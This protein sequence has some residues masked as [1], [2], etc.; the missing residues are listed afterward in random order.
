MADAGFSPAPHT[1][2]PMLDKHSGAI[3]DHVQLVTLT[4]QGYTSA[5]VMQAFGDYVVTSPWYEQVGMEYGVGAGTNQNV[6][7]GPPP[8]TLKDTDIDTLMQQ[9]VTN[10][11]VPTPPATGNEYLYMLYVPHTV[12]LDASLQGFYGYHSMTSVAGTNFPYAV[13]LDDGSGDGT[14]TST[15]AHELVEAA[16]DAL[17]VVNQN[18]DGYWADR[19][20][21]DPWYLVETEAADLCDGEKLIQAGNFAVQRI[22]SNAAI[23]AGKSPCIPYDPDDVW[24]DVS[25]DPAT[26]PTIPQGG[27]ATFTLTG[28]STVPVADWDLSTYQADFSDLTDTQMNAMLSSTTINNGKQVTLTLHAPTTAAHGS[29]GGVYV[30]SGPQY[31]PWVVGFT[32]Q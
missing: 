3:L 16:T 24:Y 13:I 8:T 31:R 1:A 6:M 19:A 21:P 11:T 15:A 26:M 29:L 23:A 32:V 12:T 7:L 17:F 20:L 18:G 28:W 14:T 4:Y 27:S 30:L 10:H 9:L 2:L 22:W 25:A 5:G